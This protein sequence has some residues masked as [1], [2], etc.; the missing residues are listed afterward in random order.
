MDFLN[1]TN[2]VNNLRPA[3][4]RLLIAQPFLG[5]PDFSRSVVMLCEYD[6]KGVVGF[7]VNHNT[8]VALADVLPDIFT[9]PM[10]VYD[11]GPVQRDTLHFLH[12]VPELL[13]GEDVGNNVFWGG[14]YDALQQ[15]IIDNSC[16][17]GD[18]RLFAGYSGWTQEQLDQELKDGSWIVA[19]LKPEILFDT[20]PAEMW[21]AAIRSLGKEY[22]MLENMPRDPSL[23]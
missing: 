17:P 12:R 21:K 15:T 19:E 11:G 1:I 20:E 8:K 6:E 5:D 2:P 14:S 9:S 7:V 13:G 23:N 10:P 18:I 3:A 4:G 22:A 16:T